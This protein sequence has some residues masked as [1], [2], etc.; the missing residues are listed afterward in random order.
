MRMTEDAERQLSSKIFIS[1]F[2]SISACRRVNVLLVLL[3]FN[4]I[5]SLLGDQLP[6]NVLDQYSPNFQDMGEHDQSDLFCDHSMD[7]AVVTDFWYE[8]Q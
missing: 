2:K 3:S 7:V 8:L 5:N 6:Q 4:F 1:E